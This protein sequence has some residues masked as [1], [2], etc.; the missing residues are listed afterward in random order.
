MAYRAFWDLGS[1]PGV[2]EATSGFPGVATGSLV[3]INCSVGSYAWTGVQA[4]I[5]G[6]INLSIGQYSWVGINAPPQG[7]AVVASTIGTWGWIGIGVTSAQFQAPTG[8]G[9]G[10]GESY[11]YS[12]SDDQLEEEV[13]QALEDS[14]EIP[15]RAPKPKGKAEQEEF[16]KAVQAEVNRILKQSKDQRVTEI[17][18]LP[19]EPEDDDEL[20]LATLVTMLLEDGDDDNAPKPEDEQE[21]ATLIAML[22]E[23]S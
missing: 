19:S 18:L 13:R 14:G 3:V 12:L 20:Q 21:L 5:A 9:G 7:P 22:M 10:A 11:T 1:V 15:R 2:T 6:Q 23:E 17:I 8:S 16:R 4:S